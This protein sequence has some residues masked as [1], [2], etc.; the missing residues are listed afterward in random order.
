MTNILD[1]LERAS[2]AAIARMDSLEVQRMRAWLSNQSRAAFDHDDD[3]HQ[4][5]CDKQLE[6]LDRMHERPLQ[7]AAEADDQIAME[8]RYQTQ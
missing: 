3:A 1:T 5:R 2:D 4:E 6:R 8:R 7:T